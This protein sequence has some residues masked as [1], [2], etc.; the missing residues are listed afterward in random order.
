MA[1]CTGLSSTEEGENMLESF[2][3]EVQDRDVL[4]AWLDSPPAYIRYVAPVVP[5][6]LPDSYTV[7]TTSTGIDAHAAAWTGDVPLFPDGSQTRFLVVGLE[8]VA[9]TYTMRNL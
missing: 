1:Y 9:K 2:A 5:R 4:R 3:L 7:V 6:L 8:K